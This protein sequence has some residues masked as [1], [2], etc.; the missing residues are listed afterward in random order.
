MPA[1]P[2]TRPLD[3]Q[4][5]GSFILSTLILL[6]NPCPHAPADKYKPRVS[7]CQLN[8]PFAVARLKRALWTNFFM[9]SLYWQFRYQ[10][11]PFHFDSPNKLF[12]HNRP[13]SVKHVPP[14]D[15]LIFS[16]NPYLSIS[17][18]NMGLL[19]NSLMFLNPFDKFMF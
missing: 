18:L 17:P 16:L 5:F 4:P 12:R 9:D 1:S 15:R 3:T 11:Q 14:Q 7:K 2:T 19:R 13:L 10:Q 6:I 8:S